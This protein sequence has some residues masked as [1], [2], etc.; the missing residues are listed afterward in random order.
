MNNIIKSPIISLDVYNV[1]SPTSKVTKV[2]G[3]PFHA[4]TYR[5]KG[6]VRID[7]GSNSLLSNA[8][9]ITLT[10]KGQS[11]STEILEDT[12]IIAIH[13]DCLDENMFNIPFVLEKSQ[14]RLE[15]LFD[16]ILD[17]YSANGSNNYSCYSHF[18][19]LLCEVE[20]LLRKNEEKKILPEVLKAKLEIEK[21]FNDNNFNI[22]SLV[23]SLSISPSYL[24]REFKKAF[25]VTPIDYLK[26]V[27]LQ[28]ALSL[29]SSDYY[30]IDELAKICGYGSTSYFIQSFHKS[31]G[32]S[33][34][35][36]KEKFLINKEERCKE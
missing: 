35:K 4:L 24:R 12:H 20:E 32:Y 9:C 21:N 13:F 30:S 22:D 2:S 11:Y 19:S 15:R 8:G 23:S 26:H 36:Y 28:K 27:R 18:Y 16:A 34:L 33:P 29:L 31:T 25:S 7:I 1:N 3:R 14:E 10:P 6:S 5:K 17:T